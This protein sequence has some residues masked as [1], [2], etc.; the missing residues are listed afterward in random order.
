MGTF[1]GDLSY[2][3]LLKSCIMY[4]G[5]EKANGSYDAIEGIAVAT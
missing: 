1:L 5:M 4:R 2:P 3:K